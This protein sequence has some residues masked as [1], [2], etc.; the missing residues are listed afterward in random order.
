MTVNDKKIY[1]VSTVGGIPYG[2]LASWR[3][4]QLSIVKVETFPTGIASY[5]EPI[6]KLVK[7]RVKKGFLVFIEEGFSSIKVAGAY[8]VGMDTVDDVAGVTVVNMAMKQYRAMTSGGIIVYGASVGNISIPETNINQTID[9]KG[10][11]LYELEW[12]AIKP[13]HRALLLVV[14]AVVSNN[15]SHLPVLKAMLAHIKGAGDSV[16]KM[17]GNKKTTIENHHDKKHLDLVKKQDLAD[18]N[19]NH[20]IPEGFTHVK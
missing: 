7:E 14:Y 20:G 18:I 8:Q 9:D 19:S 12:E 3:S 6:T 16:A 4:G 17:V 5:K 1:C 11:T 2:V 15:P 10:R 13:Q